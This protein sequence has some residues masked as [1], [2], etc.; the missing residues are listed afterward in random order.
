MAEDDIIDTTGTEKKEKIDSKI[1]EGKEKVDTK[2]DERKEKFNQ[3]MDQG[4]N[5][6]D[7]MATDLS[8]GVDDLF[9]NVK[10]AQKSINEKLNDYKKNYTNTLKIDL[11]E[12]ETKYY[13][14]VA[15]PGINKDDVD[16][17]AGDYEI[18]IQADFPSFVEE[19]DA[20][21]DLDE[22]LD[23]IE[24]GNCVKNITF[25]TQIDIENI[26]AKFQNG[27]IYITIP[28]IQTPKQKINVE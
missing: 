27:A 3:R 8:K 14:K 13:L 9:G 24:S 19:I 22:I 15:V 11:A 28:K 7:K 4:K 5:F 20:E 6:A 1:S 16:I 25:E 26:T 2:I 10:S 23:E 21:D 17:N 18:N 12:S